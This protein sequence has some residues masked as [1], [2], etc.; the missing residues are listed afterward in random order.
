MRYQILIL[1]AAMSLQVTAQ[2]NLPDLSD[3]FSDP[4][5][6][7]KW[8]KV[9]EDEGWPD[10]T[11]RLEVNNGSLFFEPGKSGWFNDDYAPF[12]YKLVRGD[13]DVQMRIKSTGVGGNVSETKWSLGGL[14]VRHPKT[15]VTVKGQ[16]RAENWL[17]LN[18]GVAEVQGKQ[19]IE[20][21]YTLNSNSNLKLREARSEWVTLR[22]VR[23]GHAFISLYKYDGDKNWTVQDRYYIQQWSPFLQVGVNGYTGSAGGKNDLRIEVDYIRFRAPKTTYNTGDGFK[24]WYFNVSQNSLTDYSLTNQELLKIIGD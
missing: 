20:S 6:L 8:K 9:H 23:V 5:T 1:M 10:Q 24:D 12:F 2:S 19:V 13:F 18:T 4:V 11:S 17:F 21:K 22:V 7:A 14:M 16:P 15:H 3:E